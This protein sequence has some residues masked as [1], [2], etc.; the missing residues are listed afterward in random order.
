MRFSFRYHFLLIAT[1]QLLLRYRSRRESL[2][3]IPLVVSSEMCSNAPHASLTVKSSSEKNLSL[4]FQK[5]FLEIAREQG[6]KWLQHFSTPT[7]PTSSHL[8]PTQAPSSHLKPTQA[9]S[10]QA[11][12]NQAKP[13]NQSQARASNPS[14][15]IQDKILCDMM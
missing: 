4:K 1:P 10:S 9:N 14:Q 2:I 12:P 11:M 7:P 5:N 15:A 3:V 6:P 8:H 13:C